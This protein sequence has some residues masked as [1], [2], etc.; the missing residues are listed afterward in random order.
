[1]ASKWSKAFAASQPPGAAPSVAA[2][3]PLEPLAIPV[4]APVSAPPPAFLPAMFLQSPSEILSAWEKEQEL[5]QCVVPASNVT[6]AA[7][8]TSAVVPALALAPAS[9]DASNEVIQAS[10][11]GCANCARPP[12]FLPPGGLPPDD[13]G[14]GGRRCSTCGAGQCAPGRKTCYKCE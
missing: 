1:E 2:P 3:P 13:L 14:I 9:S 12:G 10:A 11:Q 6:K 8:G 4:A 5:K 7:T